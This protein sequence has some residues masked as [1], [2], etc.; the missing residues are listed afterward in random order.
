MKILW[1]SVAPFVGTGYGQ[2]TAL[3]T[4][5]IKA[6]GHDLAISA[7]YG[8]GGSLLEWEGLRIYP[9]DH[10]QYN[11]AM[12]PHYA[13]HHAGTECDPS[14]VLVITLNDVWTMIDE[15]LRT[16][17][18]ASWVPVDHYPVP[19]RVHEFFQVT[20]SRPIAMSKFGD[21]ALRECGHDPLYVPHGV[22]TSVFKP[23]PDVGASYRETLGIP[24]DAFVIGMVANNAGTNPPRKSFPQIFQAFSLFHRTHPDAILYLHTNIFGHGNGMNLVAHAELTGIPW[25]AVRYTDQVQYH[26]GV[27]ADG[28]AAVYNVFDVLANASHGEGFG[29]PIIEAQACGKPVIVTDWTAMP[30]LVGSGWMVQGDHYY[31]AAHGAYWMA[32]SVGELVKAFEEAYDAKGDRVQAATAR[33]FA[34]AYDVE[35]VTRDFWVPALAA[36][37]APKV[38]PPLNGNRAQ[39]RAAAKT[40][41]TA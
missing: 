29:V 1:N 10:T 14:E 37:D 23:M 41:V 38:V 31:H 17:R 30:E 34:M 35:T 27:P 28:V 18:L 11:V 8:V 24:E 4:P 39:R 26:F 33:E 2:Q 36:L 20:G 9:H 7:V 15:R 16:L 5:R 25:E 13:V 40:K 19:P 32:P 12:M 21:E 22:D 3:F 6:L